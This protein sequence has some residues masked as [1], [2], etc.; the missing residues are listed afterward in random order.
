MATT[1]PHHGG[2]GHVAG[3]WTGLAMDVAD[4]IVYRPLWGEAGYGG[5]RFFPL[6]FVLH[7]LLIR[8]GVSVFTA[9]YLIGLGAMTALIAGAYRLMRTLGVP[10]MLAVPF[11]LLVL[12]PQ[13]S[14]HALTA[15]RGDGLA[16]AIKHLGPGMLCPGVR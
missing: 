16:A 10:A 9:G 13:S 4:G 1:L 12:S 7:G 3:A 2:L 14:Q 5:T 15:I 11:A 8:G 6:H